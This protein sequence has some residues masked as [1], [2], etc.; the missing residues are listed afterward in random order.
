MKWLVPAI[1]FCLLCSATSF[2]APKEK[3]RKGNPS[4]QSVLDLTARLN[5]AAQADGNITD[6]NEGDGSKVGFQTLLSGEYEYDW[7]GPKDLSATVMSQYSA[8]KIFFLI[9]VQD[10]VVA[11]K[12]K[13]WKSDRVEL[14]L[15]PET[16]DGKSLGPAR[17][18]LLDVGPQVDGGKATI[19]WLSG[20]GE[21]V[22]G[23]AFIHSEGYDF[24]VGVDFSALSKTTPAM[25]G[26]MR[27][28]VLVRD[29]DQDDP[30]EDEASVGSCPID[31]KKSSSIKRDKMGKIELKL[32]E[33]TWN[34]LLHSDQ[35][36]YSK[37]AA[38]AKV[39]YDLAGTSQPEIIA[40]AGDLLV[41]AGYGLN[42]YDK[43]TWSKV[44]LSSGTIKLAP[45]ITIKDVDG[46]KKPEILVTR[47][48]HC[49]NGAMNADRTYLFRYD[50]GGLHLM[51]NYVTEQRNDD[52]SDGFIRNTY[53]FS[54]T[55]YTQSL[56]RA[57]S[58]TMT[59]CELAATDD[60]SSILTHQSS[61][62]TRNVPYM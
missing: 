49:T 50:A 54:K 9:Q 62:T 37:D 47:N 11:S 48:E 46:D 15:A 25:N 28:C 34:A 26:V 30:N 21:G 19:K 39:Q 13:Q 12:K 55:G 29:W 43:L 32:E 45:E 22:E 56:D 4:E 57:S 7:T 27:Y 35:E 23:V 31:P 61:E 14:W 36:M 3:P 2:A 41:V 10:N 59:A 40:F 6:W 42:G 16:A 1:C 17:G 8:D 52:G 60:M 5:T 53:K 44:T 18:I 58:T 20:K 33:N 24:E 51:A 38:W